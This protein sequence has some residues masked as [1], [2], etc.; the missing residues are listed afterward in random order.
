MNPKT[1]FSK[2]YSSK[3]I[4]ILEGL[5][6]LP[7][8]RECADCRSR[9]P[10]WASINLGI[11]IC[12]QCSGIHRGLG[13]HISKVRSATLDTWLPEMV[14]FMQSMGN[15]KANAHWE[16]ELPR[17][18]DRGQIENFIRAKYVEK[19]W[20]TR[21]CKVK[22]PTLS[23]QHI[24]SRSSRRYGC[25]AEW[26]NNQHLL[27]ERIVC[28]VDERNE[29]SSSPGIAEVQEN[30]KGNKNQHFGQHQEKKENCQQTIDRNSSAYRSVNG[31]RS[32]E[33]QQIVYKL[34]PNGSLRKPE[35]EP[36]KKESST[37]IS[38]PALPSHKA[39]YA[40]EL[41]KTLC[42]TDSVDNGSSPDMSTWV[43]FDSDESSIPETK[44]I[45]LKQVVDKTLM[46][47]ATPKL[48]GSKINPIPKIDVGKPMVSFTRYV[49]AQH[50]DVANNAQSLSEK[51][52]NIQTVKF[53]VNSAPY[54]VSSLYTPTIP[55]KGVSTAPIK[56]PHTALPVSG[57]EYDFSF[58]TQGM[59]AKR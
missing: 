58:L 26:T 22:S 10:R 56:R 18:Y 43:R 54:P 12:L 47:E 41:F 25:I 42:M 3:H 44:Q 14:V 31:D 59:F 32:K 17:N 9:A 19:R 36:L 20:I 2:E 8:N 50:P 24:S 15:E 57:Y 27:K 5:L 55:F 35:Q 49:A 28:S 33:S 21:E 11:F 53:A 38:L 46:Q 45:V 1:V 7:E 34:G 16:V 30:C 13:V 52:Q 48:S 4:K 40:D 23:K 51:V 37:A 39:D 6:K 29:A